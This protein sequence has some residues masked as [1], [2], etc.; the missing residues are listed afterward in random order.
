MAWGGLSYGTTS[1]Y[2]EEHGMVSV[3]FLKAIQY[4]TFLLPLS[5]LMQ[6][7]LFVI[8]IDGFFQGW[9]FTYITYYV[10]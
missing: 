10:G 1:C 3:S 4:F 2:Q 6:Y 5:F 8:A 9:I 7:C